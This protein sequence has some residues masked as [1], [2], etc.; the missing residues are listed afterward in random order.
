M[1]LFLWILL[2]PFHVS[3]CEVVYNTDDHAVQ[4]SQRLFLDDLETAVRA[5]SGDEKLD[6]TAKTEPVKKAIEAYLRKNFQL[7]LNGKTVQYTF[8]GSEVEGDAMWCY[9]E[10]VEQSE[11]PAIK[12]TNSLLT[13]TFEDQK[14]LV[15]FKILGDKQSFILDKETITASYQK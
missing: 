6:I 7:S 10:A 2:H 9:L 1:L 13:E 11:L 15:H 5:S 8:L 12:V 14:N 3:V 4:I